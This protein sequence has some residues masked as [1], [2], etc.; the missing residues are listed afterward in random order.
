MSLYGKKKGETLFSE[1]APED[2]KVSGGPGFFE[3][4]GNKVSKGY[5]RYSESQREK[6]NRE[7]SAEHWKAKADLEMQ[8][9]RYERFKQQRESLTKPRFQNLAETFG[10]SGNPF[11][12][13]PMPRRRPIR[14]RS[15][16]SRSRRRD[17]SFF[18]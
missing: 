10:G 6:R 2:I 8:R 11:S 15:E 12:E 18:F 17:D 9:G 4:L 13:R 5:E 3:R 16:G 1:K 14:R 7:E